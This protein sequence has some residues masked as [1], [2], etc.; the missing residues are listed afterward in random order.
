[1]LK[2]ILMLVLFVAPFTLSAQKFAHFDLQGIVEAMPDYKTAQTELE[3][4]GKQYQTS[5]EDMQKEYET[6]RD[7]YSSQINEKTPQTIIEQYSKELGEMQQK[8][9]EAN[10]NYQKDFSEKRTAKMQ[11]ILTKILDAVNAVSKEGSYVYVIDTQSAQS[12][13]IFIN[14]ALS[15]DVTTK[16]KSKL[17]I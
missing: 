10:Q 17:G 12:N 8:I 7:K 9:E 14:T 13:N 2:K 16:I 11:P 6:K 15:D 5:L 3:A 4:L 1:M